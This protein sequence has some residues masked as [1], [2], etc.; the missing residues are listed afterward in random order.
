MVLQ[1]HES[2]AIV[3]LS[4][5]DRPSLRHSGWF[6]DDRWSAAPQRANEIRPAPGCT[7]LS[8]RRTHRATS[9]ERPKTQLGTKGEWFSAGGA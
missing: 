3:R 6:N 4:A 1:G 5:A 2:S 7:D 8:S 9:P